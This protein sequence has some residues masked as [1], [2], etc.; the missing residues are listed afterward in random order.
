MNND[1]FVHSRLQKVRSV[2]YIPF[3]VRFVP[4]CKKMRPHYIA[5][6]KR[7]TKLVN[8]TMPGQE[9]QFHAVSCVVHSMICKDFKIAGYPRILAFPP[10][11]HT[12]ILEAMPKLPHPFDLMDKLELYVDEDT[13]IRNNYVSESESLTDRV[14]SLMI[15][16][17]ISHPRS[18]RDTF[19]DAVLSFDFSMRNLFTTHGPLSQDAAETLHQ[20]LFFLRKAIPRQLVE[21]HRVIDSVLDNFKDA[22]QSEEY[23]LAILNRFPKRERNEWSP[24]CTKGQSGVGYTCGLWELFHI[25]SVGITEWN[26]NTRDDR[27][28]GVS[29]EDAGKVLRNFIAH[30]FGCDECRTNFLNAYDSCELDRCNRFTPAFTS[31]VWNE[32]PLW[33]F[34]MHN[35]VNLRLMKEQAKEEKR[36]VSEEDERKTQWP[37][38]MECPGCYNNTDGSFVKEAV[39]QHLRIEYW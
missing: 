37:S 14:V 20:W 30:F 15:Q 8:E 25:A 27:S 5:Y 28:K 9:I 16:G 13:K 35:A 12:P 23:M 11:Q 32:F 29:A 18:K 17:E 7:V 34:E 6:A 4:K 22:I 10:G 19:H 26:S 33:L 31:S 2:S 3:F 1:S 39:L 24:A 21:I 36:V 38:R